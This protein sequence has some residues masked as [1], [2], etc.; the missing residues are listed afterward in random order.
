[1]FYLNC[2]KWPNDACDW[3]HC[4]ANI[5]TSLCQSVVSGIFT[6]FIVSLVISI[7]GYFHE[8]NIILEKT[9]SNIK[10]LYI[11]MMVLSKIIG[12]VLPEIHKAASME[13]L[14]FKNIS[15]LSELNVS[16]TE[17][18]DLGL[19]SPFWKWGAVS[20]YLYGTNWVSAGAVQHQKYF[21]KPWSTDY[22]VY[23]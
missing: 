20:P 19:F 4:P 10:S 5:D 15:G 14:P 2:C 21:S 9:D 11:N 12:S 23:H 6:G 8:R 22:G 7:I 17:K 3:T 13:T 16:F 18:M 1:M